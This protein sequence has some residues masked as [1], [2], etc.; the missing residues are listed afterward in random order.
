MEYWDELS[1]DWQDVVNFSGSEY[2]C[3]LSLFWRESVED[4]F[5]KDSSY[6]LIER[7]GW[8]GSPFSGRQLRR[9]KVY[10]FAE[11]SVFKMPPVGQLAVVTPDGFNKHPIY[12]SGISLSIPIKVKAE[13]QE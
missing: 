6:E 3:L 2:H 12:R 7:G 5:L 11:G 4:T 9:K 13:N 1:S 8:I 10:M